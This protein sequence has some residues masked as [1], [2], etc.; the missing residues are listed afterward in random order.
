M[1]SDFWDEVINGLSYH[2]LELL[3]IRIIRRQSTMHPEIIARKIIIRK[4]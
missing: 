3:K 2:D 1:D 4:E